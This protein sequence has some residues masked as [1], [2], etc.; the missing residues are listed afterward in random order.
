[1]L[2]KSI[3]RDI[4]VIGEKLFKLGIIGSHSGNVS[5][6]FNGRI[7]ITRTGSQL[8]FLTE[9]DIVSFPATRE[10]P[11]AAAS[12]E[13]IVHMNIYRNTDA[14]HIIHA[15]PPNL[16][17][18]SLHM[19]RII[20]L[21]AEGRYYLPE[22]PVFEAA[23]PIG[24]EEVAEIAGEKMKEYPLIVIRSHGIFARGHNWDEVLN[25][26]SVAEKS[27]HIIIMNGFIESFLQ[28]K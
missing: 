15:H 21:D 19:D 24:S 5:T 8:G 14:T 12:V 22:I 1:M 11:P 25:L 13:S 23:N 27:A 6:L 10:K 4:I 20:P 3:I 9:R 26:T 28:K 18:L 17:A 16:I 7:Y 2:F